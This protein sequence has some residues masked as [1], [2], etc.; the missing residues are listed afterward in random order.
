[1]PLFSENTGSAKFA[2][3]GLQILIT[4]YGRIANPAERGVLSNNTGKVEKLELHHDFSFFIAKAHIST[5]L[6]CSTLW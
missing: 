2:F 5:I 6:S 4:A 1:M 3:E